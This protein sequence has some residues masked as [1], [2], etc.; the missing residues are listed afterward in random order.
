MMIFMRI[1]FLLATQLNNLPE[2]NLLV[3]NCVCKVKKT[4]T[5]TLADGR[6][7]LTLCCFLSSSSLHLFCLIFAL[8]FDLFQ[9]CGHC[10]GHGDIAVSRRK[11]REDRKSHSI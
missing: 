6:Y 9:D 4:M 10:A 11:R 5:N 8:P 1:A 7:V 2:E 3:N